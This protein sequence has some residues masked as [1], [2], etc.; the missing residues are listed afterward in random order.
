MTN[1]SHQSS[2][3][4]PRKAKHVTVF[5]GGSVGGWSL[6]SLIKAGITDITLYDK[7]VVESHNVPMSLFRDC[8][9]GRRKV[10][11]LKEILL[12]LTGV[13]IT[14][15]PEFYTGGSIKPG[16]VMCHVDTMEKGR[17]LIFAQV[18]KEF[19]VDVM[20]DTRAQACYG[21][22]FTIVPFNTEDC[23]NYR[24][25]SD[26]TDNDIALRTCGTHG[27][28][29]AAAGLANSAVGSLCHFWQTGFYR[30]KKSFK[31]DRLEQ[32]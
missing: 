20:I 16:A 13:E 29:F 30:W 18:Q 22:I 27:I 4:D 19:K 26:F 24:I 12:Y 28:S 1:H 14:V 32:V 9:V 15:V 7:D 11:A 17:H 6:L 23:K 3:F 2:L 25:S 10:D 8:D 21:E 5:G 31:Y